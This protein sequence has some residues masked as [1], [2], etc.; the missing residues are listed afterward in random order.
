MRR[1]EF[2]R[3]SAAPPL[4]PVV[5]ERTIAKTRFSMPNGG[6]FGRRRSVR[7]IPPTL[8]GRSAYVWTYV[9]FAYP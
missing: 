3:S 5:G 8:P 1:R 6:L 9:P 2:A 4:V 7:Q